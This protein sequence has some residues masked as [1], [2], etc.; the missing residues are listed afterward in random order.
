MR[1]GSCSMRHTALHSA[2]WNG[3]VRTV[4]LLLDAGADRDAHD[5]QYDATPAGWARTSVEVTNNAACTDAVALLD[6]PS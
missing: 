2:A 5:A 6:A 1:C 4:R 3:D